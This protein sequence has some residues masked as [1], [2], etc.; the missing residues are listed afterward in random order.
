MMIRRVVSG[1]GC[2]VLLSA[3]AFA[4]H[5]HSKAPPACGSDEALGQVYA[6]L[7]DRF[8]L[9][10]IFL[11]D[12]RTLSG[13]WFSAQYD[14]SAQVTEIRGNIAA[15]GMPW[16]AVRYQIVRRKTAP[17]AGVTVSLGGSVP[18][19]PKRPSFWQRVFGQ[20]SGQASKSRV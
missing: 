7:R 3:G 14:C 13:G 17:Y 20:R 2:A 15:S 10:S 16:R 12:I 9:E 4:A 8:H 19:A 6:A 11:N 1:I 18:L 5:L